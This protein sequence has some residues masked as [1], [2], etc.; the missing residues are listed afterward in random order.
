[1]DALSGYAGAVRRK[2]ANAA[3]LA[4]C[5]FLWAAPTSAG[6]APR[7]H[8]RGGSHLDARAARA[9]GEL[10]LSGTLQDDAQ[11]P[12]AG[13]SVVVRN[14]GDARDCAERDHATVKMQGGE[15]I[16]LTDEAGRFCIRAR[17]ARPQ[18]VAKLE[19]RGSALLEGTS[20]DV[21]VDLSRASLALSF[22]PPPKILRLDEAE[23]SV[24]AVALVDDNG[25]TLARSNLS[26]ALADERG[27]ELASAVTNASGRAAFFV[28][29]PLL[30][31]PGRGQLRVSFA[32]DVDTAAASQQ[33]EVE[34][35]A[36]VILALAEKPASRP[37]E[38]GIPLGLTAR[39]R[40]GEVAGGSVE[41]RIGDTLVG[42]A[43]VDKGVAKLV[44]TFASGSAGAGEVPIRVRYVPS[45]PW[46]IPSDDLEVRVPIAEPS[47]LRQVPLVVAGLAVIAW[48]VLG[49]TSRAKTKAKPASREGAQPVGQAGVEVVVKSR[50]PR[51]GWR[52]RV[53]DAHDRTPIVNARIVLRRP[54]F[55]R[56]QVLART[57][58]DADGKFKLVHEEV[59]SDDELVV[60]GPLHTS[61]RQSP[62][63]SGEIVVALVLRKRKLLE[64]LVAWARL[65]GTPFDVKPEATPGHVRRAAGEDFPTARWA[66]AVEKAAYGGAALDEAAEAEI[67]RL[68]PAGAHKS[69]DVDAKGGKSI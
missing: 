40:G 39:W 29:T 27:T 13:E 24:T 20:L 19:W 36:R 65:R 2:L 22:D 48:L 21:P 23:L 59:R 32:G 37:P 43:R 28:K 45:A 16:A 15:A 18:F 7:V 68:E 31:G 35:Q 8:V 53:V 64:R 63:P 61:L 51:M 47:P 69:P 12:L 6:K 14:V 5:V 42:A 58:S 3:V 1:M 34:R 30:A 60:D 4:S 44:V 55:D 9:S 33:A 56:E 54:A 38:D 11:Q 50:D 17:P 67:E 57:T 46:W 62:P 52:G 10:V 26:L 25:L 41:A 66:D 49:R